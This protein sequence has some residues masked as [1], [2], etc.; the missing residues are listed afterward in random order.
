MASRSSPPDTTIVET[1]YARIDLSKIAAPTEADVM[2]KRSSYF[3]RILL[4]G[5]TLGCTMWSEGAVAQPYPNRLIKLVVPY[6][7]GGPSDMVARTIAD[8]L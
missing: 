2:G 1:R 6:T 5:V 4:A 3:A 8:K 7:A